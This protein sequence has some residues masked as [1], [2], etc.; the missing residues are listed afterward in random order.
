MPKRKLVTVAEEFDVE[1][2]EAIKIVKEK[3]PAEYVTGKGKNTWISEE[4]QDILDDGLFI[5]EII[6]RNYI[7]RVLNECPNPRYNSVHC[8]E[9]GKRVPVMIPRKLHGKLIGKAI[10]FE[11]VEDSKGVSYRYVKK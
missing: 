11:A 3:I 7:G 8:R 4:A 9:I 10:T 5:D 2:D 6:P 1:F